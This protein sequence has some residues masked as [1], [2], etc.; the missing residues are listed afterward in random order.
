[1]KVLD[2]PLSGSQANTTA[3]RNRFGQYRRTRATPVN[4]NTP[5]QSAVRSAFAFNAASF[6]A[7]TLTQQASWASW[8]AIHPRVD[9]LGQT[10]TMTP[11]QAFLAIALLMANAGLT[12]PTTAP[13]SD[14]P[15]A[16]VISADSLTSELS[17]DFDPSP[18]AADTTLLL[19]ASPPKTTGC[20]FNKD[21]RFFAALAAAVTTPKDLTVPYTAKFGALSVGQRIFVRARLLNSDGQVSPYSA[22]L[23]CDEIA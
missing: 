11:L 21:F 23:V 4:P 9:S 5:E 16:P 8:A 1:M 13:T 12:P 18:I 15:A 22:V 14:T 17:I 6:K 3:S 20:L 2:V 7:L 19:E 10:Y